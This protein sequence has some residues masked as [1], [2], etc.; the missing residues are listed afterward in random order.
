MSYDQPAR[1]GPQS[2]Q[3]PPQYPQAQPGPQY[4]QQY[5]QPAGQQYSQQYPQPPAAQYPQQPQTP[6][7]PWKDSVVAEEFKRYAASISW[8]V[9]EHQQQPG[10]HT[11]RIAPPAGRKLAKGDV[12]RATVM[13]RF[14]GPQ[15]PA[16]GV[17]PS[18]ANT[19]QVMVETEE[20][21]GFFGST[22]KS[23]PPFWLNA[24]EEVDAGMRPSPG[25]GEKVR[26]IMT[27]ARVVAP[28]PPPQPPAQQYQQ[29]QAPQAP[30]PP[31]YQQPQPQYTAQ[32]P[33]P[34]PAAQQGPPQGYSPKVCPA[35]QHLNPPNAVACHR[36]GARV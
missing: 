7:Q 22:K 10:Q 13:L 2:Q 35:C 26:S 20:K 29:P 6:P 12:K 15:S 24:D 28:P 30:A 1:P 34:Q 14:M 16:P 32:Y 27:M 25:L 23:H 33:Q 4:Q 17:A 11:I 8:T 21:A 9:A 5:Q 31:Q 3:I 36:C 18:G 19:I